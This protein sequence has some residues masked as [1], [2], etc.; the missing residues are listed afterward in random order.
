MDV[1]PVLERS[2]GTS[3]WPEGGEVPPSL[4]QRSTTDLIAAVYRNRAPWFRSQRKG[5]P[6][7]GAM[8]PRTNVPEPQRRSAA[9]LSFQRHHRQPDDRSIE[10]IA[11]QLRRFARCTAFTYKGKA[12]DAR[13]IGHE[14][15]V[16]LEGSVLPDVELVQVNSQSGNRLARCVLRLDAEITNVQREFAGKCSAA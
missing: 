2:T 15:D 16:V 9:G 4:V 3:G 10:S 6:T 12:A 13:Q 7:H 8:P 1:L 11:R 14:L 5:P